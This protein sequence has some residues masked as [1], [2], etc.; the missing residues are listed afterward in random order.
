MKNKKTVIGLIILLTAIMLIFSA[1]CVGNKPT[2]TIGVDAA[3]SPWEHIDNDG[4][5]Q[6]INI[7]LINLI[8]KNQGFNV[9]Y[10]VPKDG[11]WEEAL[12][13]KK[14]DTEGTIVMTPERMEKYD[15]VKMPFEPT[16]YL[17][18]VRSDSGIVINDVLN[19]KVSIAVFENSVYENWLKEHFGEKYNEMLADGKIILKRT[20]DELAF[21]VLSHEAESAIA[22]TMTLSSQLNIYQPLKFA[23]Y[24]GEPKELGFVMRKGDTEI[25]NKFTEGIKNIQNTPE[26]ASLIKRYNMQYKKATY[27]V[28]TDDNN[29]PWSFVDENGKYSGFD[30]EMVEYIADREGFDVE[31]KPY[32]WQNNV[33]AIIVGDIDMW[34]S[35]MAI[36][37][38]RLSHVAFSDPYFTAGI[39]IAVKPGSSLTKNDF[40][41]ADAK[42]VTFYGTSYLEWLQN[43]LGEDVYRNK[44]RDSSIVLVSENSDVYNILNSGKADF[45]IWGEYQIKSEED[46][47]K[48]KLIYTDED[49]EKY[50]IAMSNGNIV[51]QNLINSGLAE[52]E[53]SGRKAELIKK[54]RL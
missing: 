36:N 3:L 48:L 51:L 47:G 28:G 8:A 20:A 24:I 32:N 30:I 27:D 19:G 14:I 43:Y 33:N 2:Y 35:S 11:L 44:L 25:Y 6:G 16:R 5:P 23:G 40:D 54:Y 7:D 39:S 31:Y 37:E 21:S 22:G 46:D 52:F 18:I 41:K 1:G 4:N 34:A 9:K 45:V 53:S 42:I 49:A 50:G 29:Y 38:D 10:Y 12:T 17:V 15:F 13:G 26:F